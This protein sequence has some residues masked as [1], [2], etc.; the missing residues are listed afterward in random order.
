MNV[1][2]TAIMVRLGRVYDNLMVDL[3]AANAKLEGRRLE[4]LRRLAPSTEDEAR[5]ALDRAGGRIKLAALMLRGLGEAAASALLDRTGD[6][7]RAAFRGGRTMTRQ[8]Q[9]GSH[10]TGP[11]SPPLL[12]AA[13]ALGAG[14][15]AAQTTLTIEKSWRAEDQAIWDDV[16]A[17][18][19][20]K[21]EHPDI[22]VRVQ[23]H[24]AHR[25][26]RRAQRAPRR[27]HRGRPDR[28]PALRRLSGALR[29]GPARRH[30]GPGGPRQLPRPRQ[31]PPGPPTTARRPSAC[32]WPR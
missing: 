22:D 17:A 5:E 2:S 4:I 3:A 28:L 32:R 10:A 23:P 14:H 1:L 13:L 19:P 21:H 20:S 26:Q 8:E 9:G 11:T 30:L 12:A 29:E 18:P 24:L 27:R 25:V 6:D 31:A 15:A 16:A 7:L